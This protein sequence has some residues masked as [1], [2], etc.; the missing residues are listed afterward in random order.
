MTDD[1]TDDVTDDSQ[2]LLM[3]AAADGDKR[4][5]EAVYRHF[6]PYLFAIALR[7]LRRRDWAEE[8][9]HDSFLTVWQRAGSFDPALS[10][11]RT[12]LTHIVRNR[13]IDYLRLQ[14]N[15]V[16]KLEEDDRFFDVPGYSTE[17]PSG[18]ESRRLINCMAQLSSEQRQSISLAYYQGLS[19][20]EIALHLSQPAGTIKSWIRRALTQLKECVGI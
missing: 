14:D 19:H 10:A 2:I 6:S 9:L 17:R 18:T 7:M 20:T 13:A 3:K 1:V 12:W 16:E 8:V 4:A 5:F 15:R 11:P